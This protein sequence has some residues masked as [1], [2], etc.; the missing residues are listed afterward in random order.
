MSV[1]TPQRQRG[2]E[3][4]NKKDENPRKPTNN[5][6]TVK[7]LHAL[8]TMSSKILDLNDS[9]AAETIQASGGISRF[10]D[11][12]EF[13][14]LSKEFSAETKNHPLDHMHS[15]EFPSNRI[16]DVKPGESDHI[17]SHP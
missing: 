14:L 16:F 6:E 9:I 10:D 12:Y 1:V 17:D 15:L 4:V 5:H 13:Q 7:N 2:S 8:N 3:N 11:K